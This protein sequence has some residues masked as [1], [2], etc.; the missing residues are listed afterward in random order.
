MNQKNDICKSEYCTGCGACAAVCLKSSITLEPNSMGAIQ[1]SINYDTCVKCNACRNICPI[2]NIDRLKF[3]KAISAYHATSKDTEIYLNASSGGIATQIANE[4]LK[5]N[6]GV[7]YAAVMD[8]ERL[9][10]SHM[11]ITNIKQLRKSQK[12]KYVQSRIK[13][14]IYHNVLNDI[15]SGK[16]VL[17]IGTPCQIAGV[18]RFLMKDYDNII[19]VE[20]ICHGTPGE[21][22]LREYMELKKLKNHKIQDLQFRNKKNFVVEYQLEYQLEYQ[23]IPLTPRSSLY[24]HGFMSGSI[25]RQSC[26]SCKFAKRERTGD[27]T[28][29]D[30]EFSKDNCVYSSVIIYT[31]KGK[32]IFDRIS[33]NIEYEIVDVRNMLDSHAQLNAPVP[34][35]KEQQK[36]VKYCELKGIKYALKNM[37]RKKTILIMIRGR[38]YKNKMMWDI[39]TNIPFIN[40]II[41]Y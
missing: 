5:G 24:Y 14:E 39:L 17:F 2:I 18:K 36:F 40:K 34:V 25:Y 8:A 11:R 35:N 13:K 30:T 38:I 23:D 6:D 7:V 1:P 12:S 20:L 10:V 4:I 16:S 37:N 32:K 28:L 21:Q 9:Q 33:Y 19:Y 22:V 41:R 29:G 27:I 31:D 15:K 3:N 26:H